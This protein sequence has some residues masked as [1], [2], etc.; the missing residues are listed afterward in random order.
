M[1]SGRARIARGRP[2]G[3]GRSAAWP[4]ALACACALALAAACATPRDH[5]RDADP[6][7]ADLTIHVVIENPAGSGEK[8]EVRADGSLVPDTQDG[9]PIVIAHLPWPVNG[10]MI[11]RTLL[12]AEL[13]GDG[14]PVDVLVL[15]PSLPRGSLVRAR[16]IGLFR[17]L[18]GIERDDKV[19]A[20]LPGTPLGSVEDIEELEERFP[21]V[22][23][24]LE[25]WYLHSGGE[26]RYQVQGFGSRAAAN[27]LIG[28]CALAFEQAE[29]ERAVPAWGE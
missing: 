23:S 21:G 11:P 9:R 5:L 2:G 15:G 4:G 13:G 14:E 16:P 10:G 27:R 8:W 3:C 1:R 29:R 28:E 26:G 7:N 18:E 6:V 19:L 24:M 17:V 20:V 12:S 22:T 25:A